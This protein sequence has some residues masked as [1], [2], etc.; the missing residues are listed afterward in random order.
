MPEHLKS[1]A[2]SE[3]LSLQSIEITTVELQWVQVLAEGWA[4]PLKG[5]MR[6]D[7]FLQTIHFNCIQSTERQHRFNQSIPIV[8]SVSEEERNRLDG[9]SSL[10]LHYNHQPVAILR[11]PEFFRQPKEERCARQFGTTNPGHPYIKVSF[12]VFFAKI[13]K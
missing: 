9:V 5:F 4:H 7:E 13:T 3:A 1:I 2:Q 11:K 12:F 8:L 6:E 10:A